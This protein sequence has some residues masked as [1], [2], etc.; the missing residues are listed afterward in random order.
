MLA[1]AAALLVVVVVGVLLLTRQPPVAPPVIVHVRS[2]P[3]VR[4]CCSTGR[5]RAWS[6]T[7]T[8]PLPAASSGTVTLTLRKPEYREATRVLRL[9]LGASDLRFVMEALPRGHVHHR[10]ARRHRAA[11]GRTVTVDGQAVKGT[12]PLTVS[13]DPAREHRIAVRLE[14]TRPRSERGRGGG[15]PRALHAGGAGAA[16]TRRGERGYPL[17]VVWRGKVLEPRPALAGGG[18]ARRGARCSPWSRPP[19]SCART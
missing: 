3:R 17:D 14:G 10:L 6:R 19:I 11:G 1:A 18:R 15:R 9:P 2:E 5:T 7:E 8:S 13:V 4:R 12:T 16:G